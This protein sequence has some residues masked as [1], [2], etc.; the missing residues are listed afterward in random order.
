MLCPWGGGERSHGDRCSAITHRR[1]GPRGSRAGGRAAPCGVRL[2]LPQL[3][4]CKDLRCNWHFWLLAMVVVT[5]LCRGGMG[6]VQGRL[7]GTGGPKSGSVWVRQR[8]KKW[9]SCQSVAGIVKGLGGGEPGETQGYH[10]W[11][12]SCGR[13]P[14]EIVCLGSWSTPAMYT[15]IEKS[16]FPIVLCVMRKPGT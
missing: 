1:H 5:E 2:C 4:C 14:L 13:R 3:L 15:C 11:G 7:N 8:L 10:C 9:V 6:T 12:H 16:W